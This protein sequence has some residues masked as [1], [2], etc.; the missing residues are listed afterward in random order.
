[1]RIGKGVGLHIVGGKPINLLKEYLTMPVKS[2]SLVISTGKYIDST[3]GE[4]PE[5]AGSIIL[6]A[7]DHEVLRFDPGGGFFVEG[8]HVTDDSLVYDAFLRFLKGSYIEQTAP[9]AEKPPA[10]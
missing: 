9:E 2:G 10:N 1:M 6:R 8:R 3:K 4:F 7:G 5:K